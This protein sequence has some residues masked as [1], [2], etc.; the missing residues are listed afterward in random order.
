M[1]LM[2]VFS[3]RLFSFFMFFSNVYFNM[4]VAMFIPA[5]TVMLIA[6]YVNKDR[7]QH[8]R[9]QAS[10]PLVHAGILFYLI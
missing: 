1:H 5:P 7:T 6:V 3:C 10:S 9:H 8:I 4:F 2:P